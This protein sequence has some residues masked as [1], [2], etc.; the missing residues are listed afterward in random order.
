MYGFQ[1][2]CFT[3]N[4]DRCGFQNLLGVKIISKLRAGCTEIAYDLIPPPL[5]P[6]LKGS[7]REKMK[8]GIGLQRLVIL[9]FELTF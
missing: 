5:Q 1:A 9:Q 7:V 2:V 6:L 8:G 3:Y 4:I